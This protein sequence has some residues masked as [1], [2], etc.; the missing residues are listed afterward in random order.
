M[1]AKNPL[2]YGFRA[3][4][5]DPAVLLIEILWRWSFGAVGILLLLG[6]VAMHQ[7]ALA[8]ADSVPWNSHD[9][10]SI[11]QS[12]LPVVV[13]L[14][15]QWLPLAIGLL[16]VTAIWTLF[17]AAGRTVTLN[18]LEKGGVSFRTILALQL[19]RALSVWLAGAV[20]VGSTLL[21][22]RIA[23]SGA[24]SDLILYFGLAGG[25]MMVIGVVWAVVNWILTLA[26]VCCAR[27]AGGAGRSIRQAVALARSHSGDLFGTSIVFAIPRLTALVVAFVLVFLP[28]GMMTSAPQAYFAWT[29]VVTLAYFAVSDWLY[30]ARLA[31]YLVIDLP[32]SNGTALRQ[33]AE[34]MG[35]SETRRP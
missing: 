14:A 9:P 18:R 15:S 35:P 21:E 33:P 29:V 5:R 25:S 2:T 27:N 22:S 26:A 28:S 30:L 20:M 24:Q 17:G 1:S 19:L 4:R 31:G 34:H 12:L 32:E 7:N 16:A 13:E 23:D 10:V 11:A 6:F 8:A 3:I